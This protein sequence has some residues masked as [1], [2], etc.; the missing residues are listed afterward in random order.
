MLHN[1]GSLRTRGTARR[2]HDYCATTLR[3]R[4]PGED[5]GFLVLVNYYIVLDQHG[6]TMVERW[7]FQSIRQLPRGA[8]TRH[9]GRFKDSSRRLRRSSTI[10]F[11]FSV[12]FSQTAETRSHF[13]NG[14]SR[15]RAI[16]SFRRR[17][18]PGSRNHGE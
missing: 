9:P 11:F 7:C 16:G 6:Y 5:I 10:F 18:R 4:H 2:R 8:A 3:L 17:T 12:P 1:S 15:S 14:G 13:P